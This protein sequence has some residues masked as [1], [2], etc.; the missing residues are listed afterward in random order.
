[1]SLCN[2]NRY[3]DIFPIVNVTKKLYCNNL[4]RMYWTYCVIPDP[5]PNAGYYIGA[6]MI[7]IMAL[8]VFGFIANLN[9]QRI[10]STPADL[11]SSGSMTDKEMN[12][13]PLGR[14][15]IFSGLNSY[16]NVTTENSIA[17][18]VKNRRRR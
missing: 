12:A 16:S 5:N 2:L 7:A 15:Q 17:S 1:M 18:S 10:K 13:A 11:T 8:Y 14:F 9:Q 6:F 3:F 4:M